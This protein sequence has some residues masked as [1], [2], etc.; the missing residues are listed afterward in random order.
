MVGFGSFG[1]GML[2][3]D[4]PPP[5][6]LC[7]CEHEG[8]AAEK[9]YHHSVYCAFYRPYGSALGSVC[10]EPDDPGYDE[11]IAIKSRVG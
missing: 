10:F 8:K 2:P 6:L 11:A 4:R 5:R 3:P 7:Q 1:G 9:P